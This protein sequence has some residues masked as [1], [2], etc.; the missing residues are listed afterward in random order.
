[1]LRQTTDKCYPFI[2]NKIDSSS[3]APCLLIF[4]G[5]SEELIQ[6]SVLSFS[7]ALSTIASNVSEF[8]SLQGLR[9]ERNRFKKIQLR[10]H[11]QPV[12]AF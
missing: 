3:L 1:M 9:T 5:N 12:V 2:G 11:L 4:R 6:Y 7:I 8:Q 10:R